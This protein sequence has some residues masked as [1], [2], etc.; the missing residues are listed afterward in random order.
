MKPDGCIFLR[1]TPHPSDPQKCS[2]DVWYFTWFPE[3]ADEHYARSMSERASRAEPVEHKRGKLGE[4]FLGGGIDQDASV[5]VTQQRGFNSRGYR[6]AYLSHQERR[7]QYYHQ[8]LDEYLEG[9]R[10]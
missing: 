8:V 10:S 2:F 3:G 7:V 6:G 4:M 9:K 5:F 1:A